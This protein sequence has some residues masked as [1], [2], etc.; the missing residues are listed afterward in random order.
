MTSQAWPIVDARSTHRNDTTTSRDIHGYDIELD[1][2]LAVIR[3]HL[4]YP[5]PT[6]DKALE[7]E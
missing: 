4:V 3:R 5:A 2:L 1:E 6:R 7:E